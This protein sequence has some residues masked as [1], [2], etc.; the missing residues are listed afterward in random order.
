MAVLIVLMMSWLIF[1]LIGVLGFTAFNTWQG[2]AAYALAVMFFFSSMAHF[3]RMKNDLVKMIPAFFPKPLMIVYVTGV[4]EVMGALGLLL[5]RFRQAAAFCLIALLVGM[6]VA[7]VNAA[8][9][10]ILLRGK[11]VTPLWLRTPMQLFFI[12]LLWWSVRR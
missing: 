6:F 1:R 11:P 10:G 12:V 2:D 5:P 8:R 4:L 7:N 3:N 9:R